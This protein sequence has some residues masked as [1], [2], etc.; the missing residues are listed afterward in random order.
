MPYVLIA[1]MITFERVALMDVGTSLLVW[2]I[3]HN[4]ISDIGKLEK[5]SHFPDVSHE[6]E[7]IAI[8]D[9][10]LRWVTNVFEQ[11]FKTWCSHCNAKV[12]YCKCVVESR[13]K[14]KMHHRWRLESSTHWINY[15]LFTI[16]GSFVSL[17][18]HSHV[19]VN[20]LEMYRLEK[21]YWKMPFDKFEGFALFLLLKFF[22]GL[23]WVVTTTHHLLVT[24]R[25]IQQRSV[26][27]HWQHVRTTATIRFVY[28]VYLKQI[29][30]TRTFLLF[31]NQ[32]TTTSTTVKHE[33]MLSAFCSWKK[34]IETKQFI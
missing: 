11:Q 31:F 7:D 12:S 16:S 4:H 21:H 26:T 3:V 10:C 6:I 18:V 19:I 22:Q 8:F 24:C 33:N 29:H 23:W 13:T 14:F 32:V 25:W 20:W 27:W 15:R 30:K 1:I 17:T 28:Q 9:E 5:R 2:I 34:W